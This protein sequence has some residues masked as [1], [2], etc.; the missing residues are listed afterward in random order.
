MIRYTLPREEESFGKKNPLPERALGPGNY[1]P[2]FKDGSLVADLDFIHYRKATDEKPQDIVRL[3]NYSNYQA[4]CIAQNLDDIA[5]DVVQAKSHITGIHTDL[6]NHE[7][8]SSVQSAELK[9]INKKLNVI[10]EV[11]ADLKTSL[12]K[13]RSSS[14]SLSLE[15]VEKQTFHFFS[16]Q[17]KSKASGSRHMLLKG[18]EKSSSKL[19]KIESAVRLAQEK[20]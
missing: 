19:P 13:E 3:Q 16:P 12:S 4:V 2:K 5:Q 18:L 10:M 14:F 8:T 6:D 9:E 15:K 1:A 11:V 7:H 17:D 20:L